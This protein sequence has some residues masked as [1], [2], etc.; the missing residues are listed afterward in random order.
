LKWEKRW[1]DYWGQVR[2]LVISPTREL[3]EQTCG[4]VNEL[5]RNGPLALTAY[6]FN[7]IALAI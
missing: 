5:G 3:A 6:F 2:A 1:T 7:T 4:T